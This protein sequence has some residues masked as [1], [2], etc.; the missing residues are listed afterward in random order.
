MTNVVFVDKSRWNAMLVLG[1]LFMGFGGVGLLA[2]TCLADSAQDWARMKRIAPRGYVCFRAE[3]AVNVDGQLDDAAWQRV[4]WTDDFVD[5]EDTE[6]PRPRFRTRAKMLWDDT[7]FYVGA[8][9]EEPHVSGSLTQHDAV[10]FHDN[11]F[12]VFI[13]PDGDNHEYFEFEMNALNTGWDLFLPRPYK[14]GGRAEDGWEIPGLLTAVHVNGTLNKPADEDRGWSVE[15]AIPWRVLQE[16]AHRPVPPHDG[17]RWRV[18]FSRVEWQYNIVD[19]KYQ[20]VP[21]TPENNWVWSPPGIVDMH[22]PERWG[23]VQF[24]TGAPGSVQFQRDPAE[25]ARDALL[26]IYHHQQAYRQKHGRWADKLDLLALDPASWNGL[27]KPPVLRM[28]STGFRATVESPAGPAAS[29]TW[30]IRQDS[31]LRRATPHDDLDEALEFVLN[32]QAQAWNNGDIDAFMQHYWKSDELSF[33]SGGRTT[34]SWETTRQNYKRR[35]PTKERMG[36]LAF[37]AIEVQPLGADA[38]LVLGHWHLQRSPAPIGGN[39]SLVF[40][41][42]DGAWVIVHDHTSLLENIARAEQSP[43]VQG[44]LKRAGENRGELERALREVAPAEYRGMEFLIANMPDRDLTSLKA[45]FLLENVRLAYQAWNA[46]PWK[47][48]LP[49][50]IFFNNVLPYVNI[51]ESRERWRPEFVAQFQP[52]VKNAKTMSEAAAI[53]NQQIFPLLKVRYSTQRRRADQAPSESIKSGL[54]S[55]TGLSV[56]L[57]DACRAVGVPARFVGTPLWTNNSGNHSWVEVWDKGWHFTGAAEPNGMEL[58]KAWFAGQAG[59]ARRDDARHAIY[60]VSFQRTP[61]YFPLVWDS[62]IKDVFAVNVTDY[63]TS[64][65]EKLPEGMVPI[66]FRAVEQAGGARVRVPLKITD[67]SGA[68]VFTGTTNDESFDA[69]HHL[70]V[71]L[72]QGDKYT[73]TVQFP[74]GAVT[75]TLTAEPRDTPI[76]FD[77]SLALAKPDPVPETSATLKSLQEFLA[78]DRSE[79]PELAR[80]EF[81]RVPL[82]KAEAARAEKLLWQDHAAYVR[83]TRAAEMAAHVLTEGDLQMPFNIKVFGEK[84]ERGRSL[85]IAMHGG[86]NAPKEI[87]DQAWANY[88]RYYQFEEGVYVNPRAPT[89]TWNMWHQDHIDRLFSRLIENLIVFEDVDPDRVY[90]MG[91]SAGGDGVY[92]LAPRMADRFAA[93]QMAAGHPNETSPLGLRNLPFTIHMGAND[94]A[95]N[96]NKVAADWDKLL[97]DLHQQDPGGYEYLVKLHPNKGHGMDRE[98]RVAIPWM[99]KFT[100]RRFPE[101]I[102]WKQDDVQHDRFYWLAVPPKSAGDRAEVV[103]DRRGQ[104]FQIQATGVKRLIIRVNDEMIDFD[105]PVTVTS[106]GKE[107]F[108]GKV[109]RN[110]AILSAT[111]ADY[112]DPRMVFSGEVTVDLPNA[113]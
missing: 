12:E 113:E 67:A 10:I 28:T 76:T 2:A 46:A 23:Y 74:Q 16:Y 84:P 88:S 111:L 105:Q 41:K 95:Y 79:R 30:T 29:E 112:G 45:D 31:R 96:R 22:R 85:F 58:D 49:E 32:E 110:L 20:K 108:S 103:A 27:S 75:Q 107:L 37:G 59:T 65:A 54:A 33:S 60:A 34:R 7:Y 44:A 64:R 14:D 78:R 104:K 11:D 106:D 89:N 98:E 109:L 73:A 42:I 52:L 25:K 5:I 35:Y 19:G 50:D 81:A 47:A 36:N 17:D 72:K 61:L 77:Q 38:A 13:D 15:I 18:D 101:R 97:G 3:G 1:R 63:Y 51:N 9:L 83:K 93:A 24:S 68:E 4:P 56:L 87:N 53:L 94:S 70:S 86:G 80:Q 40:R 21:Q 100:R 55:C 43:A 48:D 102:V 39:F 26:E 82:T 57:I 90:L 66:A 92:Q 71:P 62:S 91:Y 6:K 99:A 8:E 69:N